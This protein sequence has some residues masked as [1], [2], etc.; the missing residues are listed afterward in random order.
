MRVLTREHLPKSWEEPQVSSYNELNH[1]LPIIPKL[2]EVNSYSFFCAAGQDIH[3]RFSGAFTRRNSSSG[4]PHEHSRNKISY[5]VPSSKDVVFIN[6]SSLLFLKLLLFRHFRSQK[7]TLTCNFSICSNL[8]PKDPDLRLGVRLLLQA[9]AAN[10]APQ[11][12]QQKAD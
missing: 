2:F 11:W 9:S 1:V 12:K 4:G 10:R 6:L 5:V 3:D 8:V 7:L